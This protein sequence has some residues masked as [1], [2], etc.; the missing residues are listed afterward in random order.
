M[1]EHIRAG[2][3]RVLQRAR[4]TSDRITKE[5]RQRFLDMLAATCNVGMAS[6]AAGAAASSFYRLRRREPGFADAWQEAI[7]IGYHRL[8]EALLAY[9]LSQVEAEDIDPERADP[10]TI[11]RSI[12]GKLDRRTV[13]MEDLRFALSL[14]NRHRAAAEGRAAIPRG[15]HRATAEETDAALCKHLDTLARQL[16]KHGA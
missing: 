5:K 6:E 16:K 4:R 11:A 1:S 12:V 7:A 2:S 3:H 15:T 14:L 9:A 13:S 8:E 10:E